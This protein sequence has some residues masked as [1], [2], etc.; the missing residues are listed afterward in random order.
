MNTPKKCVPAL[1]RV[2]KKRVRDLE[3]DLQRA[4]ESLE[5]MN[6]KSHIK[7]LHIKANRE[8]VSAFREVEFLK[9]VHK[10][11]CMNEVLKIVRRFYGASRNAM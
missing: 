7:E 10:A 2:L 4:T 3:W 6:R 11:K 9:K 8:F 5:N 1:K